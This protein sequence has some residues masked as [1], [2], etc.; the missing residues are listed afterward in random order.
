MKSIA[1]LNVMLHHAA[2]MYQQFREAI[3]MEAANSSKTLVPI[4][5]HM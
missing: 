1:F 4:W 5:Y 2:E 3:F